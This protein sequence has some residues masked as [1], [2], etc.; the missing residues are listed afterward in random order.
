MFAL[1]AALPAQHVLPPERPKEKVVDERGK[2]YATVRMAL[3]P[4]SEQWEYWRTQWEGEDSDLSLTFL[5]RHRDRSEERLHETRGHCRKGRG[6]SGPEMNSLVWPSW[7][8]EETEVVIKV[9]NIREGDW[10]FYLS[11]EDLGYSQPQLVTVVAEQDFTVEV[12]AKSFRKSE[13]W[14][15][16][17][18]EVPIAWLQM[19]SAFEKIGDAPLIQSSPGGEDIHD[20]SQFLFDPRADHVVIFLNSYSLK[21]FQPNGGFFWSVS[22]AELRAK[23]KKE[24]NGLIIDLRSQI[25]AL[26]VILPQDGDGAA[27][28]RGGEGGTIGI[29]TL[30]NE[31]GSYPLFPGNFFGAI[32]SN[33]E[34]KIS[35]LPPGRY[36]I[37]RHSAAEE[38]EVFS[39]II[40][41]SGPQ[42]HAPAKAN[43]SEH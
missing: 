18:P 5:P 27:N 4:G 16:L 43:S 9:G 3:Q 30:P 21:P 32:A 6:M 41:V 37:W 17:L 34:A 23:A 39:K 20:N 24:G 25:P 1:C 12:D 40:D 8:L 11:S 42:Y 22:L 36:R 29:D 10:W 33:H 19:A 15:L 28:F 7:S 38:R 2:A 14:N 35:G 31:D 26:S 13:E